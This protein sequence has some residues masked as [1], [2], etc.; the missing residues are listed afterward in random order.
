MPT[1]SLSASSSSSSALTQ[2]FYAFWASSAAVHHL[3]TQS[4]VMQWLVAMGFN[5]PAFSLCNTAEDVSRMYMRY[6]EHQRSQCPYLIDGLVCDVD[7]LEHRK[8]LGS[9]SSHPNYAV[10]LK[11]PH[12]GLSP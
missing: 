6:T 2:Q 1:R 4:G 12:E 8:S 11:F 7:S 5:T 10:A 3:S 9:A